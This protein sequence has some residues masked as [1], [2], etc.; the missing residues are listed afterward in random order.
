MPTRRYLIQGK[1]QGV[2]FRASTQQKANEYCI[3]GW[4]RNLS[5]GDVEVEASATEPRLEAFEAWL[6]R[7]PESARVDE[8]SARDVDELEKPAGGFEIR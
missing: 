6:R 8:L 2:F 7:G 5:T 4:V 3:C 1:V